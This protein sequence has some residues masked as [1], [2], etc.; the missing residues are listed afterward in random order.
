VRSNRGIHQVI[1]CDPYPF[2]GSIAWQMDIRGLIR[3]W[4]PNQFWEVYCLAYEYMYSG[5]TYPIGPVEQRVTDILEETRG[6]KG[7]ISIRTYDRLMTELQ[8]MRSA[9]SGANRNAEKLI[10]IYDR[11]AKKSDKEP[12]VHP[13]LEN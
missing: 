13:F 12:D 3:Y 1:V 6:E 8:T 4:D 10:D 5:K 9:R 11:L 7:G 2:G